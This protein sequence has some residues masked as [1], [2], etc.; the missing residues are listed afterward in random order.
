MA[1]VKYEQ[2]A[3]ALQEGW[4]ML[5]IFVLQISFVPHSLPP[6]V[7]DCV[8]GEGDCVELRD[9]DP[10]EAPHQLLINDGRPPAGRRA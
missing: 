2:S 8:D 6:L 9:H 4:Q 5:P 1:S 7:H 3:S 10:P